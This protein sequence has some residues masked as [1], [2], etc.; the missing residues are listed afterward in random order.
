MIEPQPVPGPDW[1][2]ATAL[3]DA[4][5][6]GDTMLA[7]SWPI[8]QHL[9]STS[10]QSLFSDEIVARIRGM[11]TDLAGQILRAQARATGQEGRERFVEQHRD[12]LAEHFFVNPALVGHC[13]ALALEWLL[14]A[15]L[16]ARH[17]LDPV[18]SPLLQRLIGHDDAAISSAA[19]AALA[20]QARFA[21][22]QRRMELPLTELPG[23][24]L[25]EILL[26]SSDFAKESSTDAS[27]RAEAKLR[28]EFDE[29][30]GRLGL[31]ARLVAA[32]GPS[33]HAA[34]DIEQ[35]GAAIFLTAL[36]SR[37]GQTRDLAAISTNEQQLAR[38]LLGL[39][40]AGLK[41]A[42]VEAQALRIHGDMASLDGLDD[43]GTRE[44]A[45]LLAQGAAAGPA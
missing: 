18:L 42:E 37:S 35:A 4:L 26:D 8:L 24:L 10:D 29:A 39:R 13:H 9:L 17:A 33:A 6:R 31:L 20:A 12:G 22:V 21:Q 7:R 16:E 38:L 19:M 40:A 3:R 44:A 32:L 43:I 5:S 25:H 36:A 15:R 2:E 14:A 27:A 23:D 45:Q 30:G 28:D 41:P 1:P 34:L 11:L